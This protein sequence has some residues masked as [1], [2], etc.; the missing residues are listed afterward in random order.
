MG[1]VVMNRVNSR[2][3]PNSIGEVILQPRQF[4]S[5]D[6]GQFQLEPG[7]EAYD[8]AMKAIMGDDPTKGCLFFYNPEI[9]TAQWSFKRETVIV[10]GGHHFTK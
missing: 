3:F 5:V 4:S 9:S 1:A 7:K 10:I 2:D 8:A 6:D